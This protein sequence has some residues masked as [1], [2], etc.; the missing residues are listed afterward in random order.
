M[1]Y[2]DVNIGNKASIIHT[3]TVGDIERFVELTGDDNKLHVDKEFAKKTEFKKPVVHG[4]LGA[5]FISTLIGTKLPGDGAL[6]YSQSL[7]FVRPVRIGDT[8]TVQAE[9]ISKNDKAKS[10]ELKIEIF[11]QNKQVVTSGVSKVKVVEVEEAKSE[12][13]TTIEGESK[14]ETVLVIG[15]SGGI[16][17][18]VVRQLVKGGFNVILHY[19]C[20]TS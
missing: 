3:I 12:N 18:A 5:S 8:I 20:K 10:I 1:K 2:A 11:N 9:V 14:R 13:T 7:E 6:W 17:R 4:M 19:A 16:G 15:G